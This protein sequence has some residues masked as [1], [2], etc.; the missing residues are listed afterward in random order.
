MDNNTLAKLNEE[1]EKSATTYHSINCEKRTNLNLYLGHHFLKTSDELNRRLEKQGMDKST[2]IRVTKNHIFKICEYIKNSIISGGSDFDIFPANESELQDQKA[3]E[4]HRAVLSKWKYDNN[5]K[6]LV[7]E[8]AGDFS[9]DG[10]VAV[11]T[12]FNPMAG[13]VVGYD[14]GIG[15]DGKPFKKPIKT[16]DVEV[17]RIFAWDLI[18][19]ENAKSAEQAP[20]LGYQKMMPTEKLKEIVPEELKKKIGDSSDKTFEIFD[21]TTGGYNHRKGMTLVREKYIKPCEKYPT[22]HFYIF[23][24]DTIIFEGPLPEGHPFPIKV[25]GFTEVPTSP[26]CVSIIRQLRPLQVNINYNASQQI[27]TKMTVGQDKLIMLGGA[28]LQYSGSHRGVEKFKTNSLQSPTILPGRSGSQFVDQMVADIAE[29]YQIANVPEL[30]EDKSS[31][32]DAQTALFRSIKD[33]QRFSIYTEKFIEFIQC[34]VQDV[35]TIK[36]MYMRPEEIVNVVGRTERINVPEFKSS[37][38]IGYQIRVNEVDENEAKILGKHIELTAMLQYGGQA[39][40]PEQVALIGRNMPFLNK[41]EIFQEA[42][43]DYETYKNIILSLDRGEQVPVMPY[44][45]ADYLLPKITT[46]M[47]KAD[48]RYLDPA[49]QQNYEMFIQELQNVKAQ[50]L[51]QLRAQQ[52]Q[53]IPTTGAMVPIQIYREVPKADGGMK[54]ERV[55]VPYDSLQDLVNK[56]EQQGVVL[57]PVQRMEQSTQANIAEIINEQQTA[58]PPQQI[59][60]S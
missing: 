6:A 56:L 58:I 17:E 7:R 5:F 25:K 12:F 15:E 54:Y 13:E 29:M 33:K 36:K 27:I 1:F 22:G 45:N 42:L 48:Y 26:R 38:N 55:Q 44:D 59:A 32:M 21:P 46:R 8:L 51:M 23:N 18:F 49:I 40:T 39:M 41:E 52:S 37:E 31:Q 53:F 35:L 11:K 16:G 34:I 2:R 4:M 10:E 30:G 28:D 57:D 24:E 47:R 60:A 20:W 14:E 43:I 3:A 9:I 19:P 50:Q